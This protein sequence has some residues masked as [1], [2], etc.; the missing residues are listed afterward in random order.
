M[1]P[2]QTSYSSEQQLKFC[3][4]QTDVDL[5]LQQMLDMKQNLCCSNENV[6]SQSFLDVLSHRHFSKKLGHK[7]KAYYSTTLLG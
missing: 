4:L 3:Q 7:R 1:E 5:L 2:K 6:K